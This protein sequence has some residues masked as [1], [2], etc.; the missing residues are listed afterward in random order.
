MCVCVSGRFSSVQF[1]ACCAGCL[2]ICFVLG[3]TAWMSVRPLA[4]SEL[5]RLCWLVLLV[6][7]VA[8]SEWARCCCWPLWLFVMIFFFCFLYEFCYFYCWLGFLLLISRKIK[9]KEKWK[10][11]RKSRR[12]AA[13][14][15]DVVINNPFVSQPVS[16]L[17]A[18]YYSKATTIPRSIQKHLDALLHWHIHKRDI[19]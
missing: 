14:Y 13:L 1:L 6:V 3:L 15:Y 19:K 9:T 5:T 8:V 4:R 10:L 7:V 12:N 16:Q 2:I 17:N 18:R 11:K